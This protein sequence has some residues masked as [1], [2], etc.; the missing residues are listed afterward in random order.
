MP[1]ILALEGQHQVGLCEFETSL[2]CRVKTSWGYTRRC[3]LSTEDDDDDGGLGPPQPQ[4]LPS[5][6]CA[7]EVTS[8]TN[9]VGVFT[10][11]TSWA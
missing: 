7:L 8:L 3:C 2:A 6:A 11:F 9:T 5:R 10:L 1:V 4:S